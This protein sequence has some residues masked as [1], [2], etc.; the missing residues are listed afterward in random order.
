MDE[1]WGDIRGGGKNEKNRAIAYTGYQGQYI[2]DHPELP[3]EGVTEG[4][5]L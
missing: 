2:S 5:Q 3:L 4:E 1:T